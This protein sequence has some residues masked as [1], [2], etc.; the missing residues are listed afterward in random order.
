M[1]KSQS[2]VR[3]IGGK[4]RGKQLAV[5]NAEGLRPTGS[6]IR[7]TLFNWLAPEIA[8]AR[9]VDLFAGSGALG[10]EALS[11]GAKRVWFCELNPRVADQLNSN[12]N[13][14]A[15]DKASLLRGD[16]M[17]NLS[18]IDPPIHIMFIDPPFVIEDINQ[19]LQSIENSGILAE[20]AAIY[21]EQPKQ[22]ELTLPANWLTRR[23]KFA[24]DVQFLLCDRA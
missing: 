23:H 24:G 16:S 6:R 18:K 10:F 22:R 19:V 14:I 1:A 21:I 7:E 15:D 9:V 8:D 20:D 2:F 12:I 5:A 4:F 17:Q 3:I 13:E 11:R